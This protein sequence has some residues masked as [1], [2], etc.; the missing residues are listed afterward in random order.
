MHRGVLDHIVGEVAWSILSAAVL[1]AVTYEVEIFLQIDIERRYCPLALGD[2][3]LL[4][5]IE[6]TIVTIHHDN[7]RALQLLHRGLVMTHDA[8]GA[9]LLGKVNELL[10]AK[11]QEIVS[12]NY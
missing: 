8:A 4:F 6:H 5:H 11:K 2:K 9:L 12:G 1:Y 3:G 10:E 7:A